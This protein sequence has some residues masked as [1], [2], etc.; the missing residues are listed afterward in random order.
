LHTP[1]PGRMRLLSGIKETTIIDD[2][3]NASPVAMER[4]IM[5]LKEIKGVKRRVA[6]LGDMMELGR[7][8]VREHE[9]VGELVAKIS[10]I[11]ITIGVRSHKIASTAIEYGMK[12]DSVYRCDSLDETRDVLDKI[13]QNGDVV[14]VKGSQSIR[15]E[16]IVEHIMAEPEKARDLLV[17]QSQ[18]WKK[19]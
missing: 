5:T 6:V 10:D 8:S 11:L 7:F 17:R 4:A 16:K 12:K 1:P 3:Y 19:I 15:A 9:K 2:T 13:L 18:I 14:L